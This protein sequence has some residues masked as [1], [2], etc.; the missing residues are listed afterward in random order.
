M[1]KIKKLTLLKKR[2]VDIQTELKDMDLRKILR[3]MH[4]MLHLINQR[5]SLGQ[6]NQ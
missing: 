6:H 5:H 4:M 1:D 2:A 3:K